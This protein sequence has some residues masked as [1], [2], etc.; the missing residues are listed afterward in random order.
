VR[1]N[2]CDLTAK[3][4]ISEAEAEAS[5]TAIRA[6]SFRFNTR[7]KASF[8]ASAAHPRQKRSVPANIGFR[9]AVAT[10]GDLDS[11]DLPVY[12]HLPLGRIKEFVHLLSCDDPLGVVGQSYWE[13]PTSR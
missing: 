6:Y 4:A 3:T 13:S 12:H 7:R 8:E 11:H 1:S 2:A 10:V 5:K 9:A